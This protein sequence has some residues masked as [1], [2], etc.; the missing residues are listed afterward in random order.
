MLLG[1]LLSRRLYSGSVVGFL[2]AARR[3]YFGAVVGFLLAANGLWFCSYVVRVSGGILGK[4]ADVG[5]N[6]T[7][8]VMADNDHDIAAD[9]YP[10]DKMAWK[11]LLEQVEA[12]VADAKEKQITDRDRGINLW[13]SFLLQ[14]VFGFAHMLYGDDWKHKVSITALS[15]TDCSDFIV[16]F[17]KSG[18]IFIGE[19]S[20]HSEERKSMLELLLF[21]GPVFARGSVGIRAK[22]ADVGADI[23]DKVERSIPDDDPRIKRYDAICFGSVLRSVAD[24]ITGMGY[25]LVGFYAESMCAA[26]VFGSMPPSP[27]LGS[28]ITAMLY[29]LL[30]S[31]IGIGVY[32]PITLVRVII[33]L[34]QQACPS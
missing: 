21:Y 11:R 34:C 32:L 24:K 9:W 12:V 15:C 23:I 30:I 19:K 14:M 3:L 8:K 18:Q 25:N 33:C 31:S 13:V 27:H 17:E 16:I 7:D 5:A 29:P 2:L 26:L 10:V 4:A 6:I 22:A 1:S 28:I 20:F